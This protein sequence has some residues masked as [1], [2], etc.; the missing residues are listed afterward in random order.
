MKLTKAQLIDRKKKAE[1][2]VKYYAKKIDAIEQE[3]KRVG[4]KWLK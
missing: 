3:E 2:R 1:K 4:F